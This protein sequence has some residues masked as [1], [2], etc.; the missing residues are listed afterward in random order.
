MKTDRIHKNIDSGLHISVI[1]L[2]FSITDVSYQQQPASLDNEE[3]SCIDYDAAENT[4]TI[5][6]D[7]S[8]LDVVQAIND[9]DILEELEEEEEGGQYLL[10]ANL[11]VDDGVTFSMTPGDGLQYL[12]IADANGIIVYGKIQI[13]GIKITSWDT[14]TNSPIFQTITGSIPRAFINLRGSEGGSIQDSE[15]SHLG[16]SGSGRR[17]FDLF[18]DGPSHDLEIR[19]SEFHN[20]WFAFFSNRAYNIVVDGNEYH[21]NIKYALDPHTGTYNMNITN[22]WLHHNPIGAICSLNCYNILVEGNV[23]HHNSD[24][25]IFFSRNMHDSIARNNQI[26]NV[27]T[28][29]MV[30]ESPNNQIYNNTIEAATSQGIRL[31]NPELPDDGGLTEDNLVYNNTIIS[32]SEGIGATRSHDNILE[33]NRFSDIESGEYLLSGNSAITIRGQNFD[34]TLIA[35]DG[36]ATENLVEIVDSGTIEVTE[37]ANDGGEDLVDEEEA[38]NKLYN[39]DNEPYRKRL[40]DGDSIIV[41]S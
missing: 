12:K 28:G 20:M 1:I 32:S 16:Y 37:V 26:Y 24:Y 4:I 30:S 34:N 21:H 33:N 7:A 18:G 31:Q 27:T 39:T 41:N 14:E 22:N 38:E 8:F 2:I 29:I 23:I 5:D 11:E 9:P 6:C 13:A 3:G 19:G 10:K 35:E 40:S 15:I 25:G 36:S 17:G